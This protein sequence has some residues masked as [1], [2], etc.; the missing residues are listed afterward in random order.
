[1]PENLEISPPLRL[2]FLLVPT[3]AMLPYAATV[4]PLRAA[5]LL[6]RQTL[7]VWRHLTIDGVPIQS[8]NGLRIEP[9]LAV[10]EDQDFDVVFVFAGTGVE[11]VVDERILDWLRRLAR[12]KVKL[13]GISGGTYLLACAGVLDGYRCTIHWDHAAGLAEVF[14]DLDQRG[15]MFEVDR[16]RLTCSGGV[17][18]L[19]LMHFLL[20]K[21]AN[22]ALAH[23]VSE[24]FLHRDAQPLGTLQRENSALMT[25]ATDRRLRAAIGLMHQ[26]LEEPI[27]REALARHAGISARQ[28]DRLSLRDFGVSLAQIHHL[29]RLKRADN[30]LQQTSLPVM[31][32]AVASGFGNASHFSRAFRRE[33]GISPSERR[34][35]ARPR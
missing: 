29:L 12:R 10:S 4:E 9:D 14:P 11:H 35:Q 23:S 17:A 32:V 34:R 1:M 3:F 19:D 15:T 21:W 16:D 5:N 31:Q 33:F 25:R 28:L 13:G 2:G 18:P 30:L 22:P 8:S 24:W 6:A 7:F 27:P 20:T 26:T